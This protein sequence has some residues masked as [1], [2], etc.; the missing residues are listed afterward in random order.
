LAARVSPVLD[1]GLTYISS[2]KHWIVGI[3][4]ST[5]SLACLGD[6]REARLKAAFILNFAKFVEWPA[7]PAAA[8]SFK[9][10][11]IGIEHHRNSYLDTFRDKTVKGLPT[12][13]DIINYT[14]PID[15]CSVL[16]VRSVDQAQLAYLQ[17]LLAGKAILTIG[18]DEPFMVSGGMIRFYAAQGKIRFEINP[19]AISESGLTVSSKLLNLAK[20]RTSKAGVTP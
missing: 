20:I 4:L 19:D 11:F 6:D 5:L 3:L 13:V 18:E 15:G 17:P 12:V 16:F 10:C 1:R 7:P 2:V 8:K 14:T 9:F